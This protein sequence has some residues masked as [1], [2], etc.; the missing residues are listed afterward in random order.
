[1]DCQFVP[2]KYMCQY[3][4]ILIQLSETVEGAGEVLYMH[5]EDE[6]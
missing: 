5:N 4:Q 1:M 3:Q 6:G 2:Q